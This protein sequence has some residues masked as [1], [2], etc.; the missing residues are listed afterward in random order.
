MNHNH[1]QDCQVLLGNLS[2]FIDGDLEERVCE[3]LRQHIAGCDNCRVVFDT[4][5]RTIYLYRVSEQGSPL[6]DDVRGRLFSRL[7]LDDYLVPG[8]G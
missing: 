1:T 4:M 8:E 7:N 6:P 3:D 5:T 2:A